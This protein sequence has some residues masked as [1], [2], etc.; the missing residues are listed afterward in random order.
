MAVPVYSALSLPLRLLRVLNAFAGLDEVGRVLVALCVAAGFIVPAIG[1]NYLFS[2][3]SRA[4]C[5]IDAWY[6]V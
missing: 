6:W 3:K 1:T 5:L 4:L 2:Q